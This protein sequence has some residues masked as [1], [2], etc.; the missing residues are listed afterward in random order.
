VAGLGAL[1]GRELERRVFRPLAAR[2][3]QAPLI[4]ALGVAI[5]AEE[6]VRLLQGARDR[7]LPPLFEG[8]VRLAGDADGAVFLHTGQVL[9]AAIAGLSFAAIL[10][11]IRR[12]RFGL[13]FRAVC[14]HPGMAALVGVD[15]DGIRARAFMLGGGCAAVAGLI[16]LLYYGGAN[17]FMGWLIGFKALTAAVA[18]GLGSVEGAMLGGLLVGLFETLWSA[19]LP[20]AERDIAIFGLLALT[21]LFRPQGLLGR[22]KP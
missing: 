13:G 6:G 15:V 4:A 14:D 18:G 8:R 7:W 1:Q 2:P 21:L 10:L 20:L 3:G 11:L 16:E 17:A 9:I 5:A 19:Y 22:V 12:S